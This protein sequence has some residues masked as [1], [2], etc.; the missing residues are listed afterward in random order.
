VNRFHTRPLP[1]ANLPDLPFAPSHSRPQPTP[2]SSSPSLKPAFSS[3][4]DTA[5]STTHT[6]LKKRNM[7]EAH[8]YRASVRYRWQGVGFPGLAP[9]GWRSAGN[10]FTCFT[11]T[12]V[13]MLTA[14]RR[15]HHHAFGAPLS[16]V[17]HSIFLPF[18]C[19]EGR[20]AGA[21]A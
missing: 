10:Q 12:K 4:Q 16:K 11:V 19:V 13:Q 18:C 8:R 9:A 7:A 6:S 15:R 20:S 17:L 2:S 1:I 5:G 3:T 14:A 21:P